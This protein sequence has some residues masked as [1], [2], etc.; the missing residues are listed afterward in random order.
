MTVR[1]DG[2]LAGPATIVARDDGG[3]EPIVLLHGFPGSSADWDEG[4]TGLA[5]VTPWTAQPF[6]IPSSSGYRKPC[7]GL[8]PSTPS[9]P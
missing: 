8:E 5:A 1:D 4:A 9:L 7:D 2:S 6:P 3:G